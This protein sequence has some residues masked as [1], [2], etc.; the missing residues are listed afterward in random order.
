MATYNLHETLYSDF[1]KWRLMFSI[2]DSSKK[3]TNKRD[4]FTAGEENSGGPRQC[5]ESTSDG[6]Q[7]GLYQG[8]AVPAWLR[9]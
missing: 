2:D 5:T 7:D 6:G 3:S 4:C 8:M 9:N 1:N